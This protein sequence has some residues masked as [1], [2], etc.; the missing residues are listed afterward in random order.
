MNPRRLRHAPKIMRRPV[1]FL[2]EDGGFVEDG[3][4]LSSLPGTF[5]KSAYRR[6]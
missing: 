1:D 4:S 2:V 5:P 3:G 6:L